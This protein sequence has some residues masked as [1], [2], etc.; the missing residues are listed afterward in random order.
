MKTAVVA[1]L[2]V[3]AVLVAPATAAE[4]VAVDVHPLARGK[5]SGTIYLAPA[6]TGTRATIHVLDLPPRATARLRIHLGRCLDGGA[7]V[8]SLGSVRANARGTARATRPVLAGGAPISYD[9][10][11]R[12]QRVMVVSVGARAV[13][14]GIVPRARG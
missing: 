11:R 5:V 7:A 10:V 1:A 12:G 4:W 3:L 6:G 2:A 9:D 13:A 8:A 14:C